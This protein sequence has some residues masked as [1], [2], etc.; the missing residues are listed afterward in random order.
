V[1]GFYE[2]ESCELFA[3]NG[4]DPQSFS[5]LPRIT[6]VNHQC[7]ASPSIVLQVCREKKHIFGLLH[8][9][10]VFILHIW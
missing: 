2:T 10:N 5:S 1:M 9:V 8:A 6:E 3:C 7:P 4:L